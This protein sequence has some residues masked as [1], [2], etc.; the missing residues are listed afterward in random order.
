MTLF[1]LSGLGAFGHE[2]G[3]V[4]GVLLGAA[5]GFVLERAGFG[6]AAKLAAQFYG[7]DNRVLKV[8]FTGIATTAASIALL[9]GFGIVD[10]SMLTVPETFIGPQIVGGLLLGVG[11]AI[12]G[13]CP[14]T[15]IVAAASGRIDGL[16]TYLGV[17]VGSLAFGF[18][19]SPLESFYLSGSMGAIRLDQL[20]GLP[21]AVVAMG[22]VAMAA[23]AF[24]AV[25]RLEKYLAGQVADPAPVR[26]PTMLA[27]GVV[28]LVSLI[29]LATTRAVAEPLPRELDHVDPT[30]LATRMIEAPSSFWLVDLREPA[31]CEA[32]RVPGATCRPA[33]DAEGTFL[34]DLATTRTLVVYGDPVPALQTWGGRVEVLDGGYAAFAAQVLTAPTLP[35]EP[36]LAQVQEYEARAA[37]HGYLT[38]SAAAAAPP[39]AVKKAAGGA[40]PA[41]KGGGC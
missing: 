3:L 37:V 35:T 33:D 32:A 12:A 6:Q 25:E 16:V 34:A 19:Y 29:P 8:M 26:L 22:V 13:Y 14:G 28:A 39:V 7:R 21:F 1:P 2:A 36:T 40:K 5:F 24:F 4:L 27:L 20:L 31:A 41:K 11:F 18:F 38:G 17:M 30:T 23:G 10:L 9:S 15:G